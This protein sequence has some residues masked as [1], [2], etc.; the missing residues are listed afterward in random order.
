MR[1]AEPGHPRGGLLFVPVSGGAGTG[2]L[3]RARLLALAAQQRWPQLPIRV[4][5][6]GAT[7][8][9]VAWPSEIERV[10]LPGS[11]TRHSAEVIATLR[12]QAPAVVVFDSTARPAQLA[13]AR[14]IGAAIVYLSSRPSA[15]RRG[16]GW[17]ALRRIDEHWSVEI[18]RTPLP[19]RWQRLLLRLPG[20]PRW[21]P[22]GTLF[23]PADASGWSAA[24]R[25]QTDHRAYLLACPGGGTASNTALYAEVCQRLAKDGVPTI[26]VRGDWPPE[27]Q[28]REGE[29]LQ[30]GA[31]PNAQLMALLGGAQ[32]ALLGAGSVLVQA[33]ALG[34]ACVGTAL[35]KDQSAR[36]ADLAATG[37]VIPAPPQAAALTTRTRTLWSDPA[38]RAAVQTAARA[39][40]LNNGLAL[41]LDRLNA[42][43]SRNS[44]RALND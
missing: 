40:G 35:A 2:E 28:Q 17:R 8:A 16:F 12:A 27:R 6:A 9:R 26:L 24:L 43:L 23:E 18:S 13:A 7:L 31:L 29:L 44:R 39:W 34:V 25:Q 33:L 4:L 32:V 10:E 30:V 1:P 42:H 36:L 11:P 15:R 19:S 37:A 21:L 14:E 3:Q 38:Q 20:A 41:A 5:A 22:L